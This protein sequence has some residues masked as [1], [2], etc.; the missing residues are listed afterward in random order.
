MDGQGTPVERCGTPKA[1]QG[2]LLRDNGTPMHRMHSTVCG[3]RIEPATTVH[4][5]VMEGVDRY[6]SVFKD[7]DDFLQPQRPGTK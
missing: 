4:T 6:K 1:S 2:Q 7:A 3:A 5:R